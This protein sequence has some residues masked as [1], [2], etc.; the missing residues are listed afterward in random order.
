MIMPRSNLAH[1]TAEKITQPA[2]EIHPLLKWVVLNPVL[3]A[4]L[5]EDS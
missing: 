3:Y 2:T 4:N 1:R 5:R